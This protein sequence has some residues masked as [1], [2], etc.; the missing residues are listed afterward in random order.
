MR[1]ENVI[2]IAEI[3][4]YKS[5]TDH[6]GTI[7]N[8]WGNTSM[9]LSLMA[10]FRRHHNGEIPKRKEVS[11]GRNIHPASLRIQEEQGQQKKK[12]EKRKRGD[13]IQIVR[14]NTSVS[15][16]DPEPYIPSHESRYVHHKGGMK[17]IW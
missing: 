7:T 1:H 2:R 4:G 9:G 8:N 5:S 10:H 16:L 14:Q 17:K 6:L 13:T 3:W 15:S 12:K 11:P